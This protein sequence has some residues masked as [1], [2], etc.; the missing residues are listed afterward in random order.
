MVMKKFI[1]N[2]IVIL[3]VICGY[4]SVKAQAY[5]VELV[6]N[7]IYAKYIPKNVLETAPVMFKKNVDK[8]MKYYE[9]HK[10]ESD[11]DFLQNVPLAYKDLHDA[12]GD[13]K[14]DDKIVICNPFE[15]Y[16]PAEENMN[17]EYGDDVYYFVVKKNNKKFCLFSILQEEG[18]L[19]FDYDKVWDKYTAIKNKITDDTLLYW[20]DGSI[21]AQTNDKNEI[22]YDATNPGGSQL[23]DGV[24]KYIDHNYT[25]FK[26]L[27][28][29]EKKKIILKYLKKTAETSGENG[30]K[31]DGKTSKSAGGTGR[32]S[33]KNGNIADDDLELSDEINDYDS[34]ES[35][36]KDK[37]SSIGDKKKVAAVGGVV[38]VVLVAAVIL[39]KRKHR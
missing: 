31:T 23:M 28:Y 7:G 27:S 21:Y 1:V 15:I 35:M 3:F 5:S 39:Y 33:D 8:V 12:I 4:G 22:V 38:I 10:N 36:S 24:E 13:L 17:N 18:K 30:N 9:K 19:K 34:S 37:N 14:D 26:N 32:L 25:K 29:S 11:Y 6:E 16:N 20:I 2:L